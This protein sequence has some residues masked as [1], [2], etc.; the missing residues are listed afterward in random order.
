MNIEAPSQKS[1]PKKKSPPDPRPP[2]ASKKTKGNE[3]SYLQEFKQLLESHLHTPQ[4]WIKNGAT[5]FL[6]REELRQKYSFA[7]PN[8]AALATLVQHS[9]LIEIGAGNGYWAHLVTKAGGTIQAF[10]KYPENNPYK[11]KKK[12]FDVQVGSERVL[13]KSPENLTLFLCWPPYN[14]PM[15][16]RALKYF[17]GNQLIYIGEP[18]GGCTGDEDFHQT[19]N[20]EW[21]LKKTVP[22]PQWPSIHDQ[23]FAYQ[24]ASH[25]QN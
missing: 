4:D 25:P 20:S 21:I 9:P 16:T 17:R 10:D 7:I 1:L 18:S 13:L 15:A 14:K 6:K 3:I 8:P 23:L 24:R 22:L 2:K 19:L 11:F 5:I 12:Y